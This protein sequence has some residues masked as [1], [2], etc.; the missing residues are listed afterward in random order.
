MNE[1]DL[2]NRLL[3][4]FHEQQQSDSLLVKNLDV[5][6]RG[7]AGGLMPNVNIERLCEQLYQDGFVYKE[8][9]YPNT[10]NQ[11]NRYSIS[12][13][14]IILFN[15]LPFANKED[16]YYYYLVQQNEK[17]R[18]QQEKEGLEI[19]SIQSGITVGDS[20]RTLNEQTGE[21][22]SH[23]K[24]INKWQ[25]FLTIAIFFTGAISAIVATCDYYKPNSSDKYIVIDTAFHHQQLRQLDSSIRSQKKRFET[26]EKAVKDSLNMK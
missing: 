3:I 20:V 16:P 12:T 4:Y 15:D 11:V 6:F 19:N 14:G 22:Y 5:A 9:I 2:L 10:G 26:F 21:F 25:K 7:M 24:G 18:R 13:K 17:T 8:T 23:Q 1:I